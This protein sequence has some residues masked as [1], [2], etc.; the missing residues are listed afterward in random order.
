MKLTIFHLYPEAM[1]L[2]G[3][4][5]NILTLVKRCQWRGIDVE[6]SNIKVG[7]KADF[8]QADLI[9]LGGG[10]DRGQSIIAPDLLRKGSQIKEAV[11]NGAV[12][13]TICGGYQLFGKYF[14]TA[15]GT[16]IK[17]IE[18][19]DAYTVAGNRRLIG[20]VI[21]E[22]GNWASGQNQE[23]LVGFEN[24]S[25]KTILLND[26]SPLGTVVKGFGN[27]GEGKTEGAVYKNAF[28]TYLHGSLLPKN[29]WF[30]DYLILKGLKRKHLEIEGLDELDDTLEMDANVAA[31]KRAMTAKTTYI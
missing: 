25:G 27:D 13:L 29:P 3:D 8:N 1:N 15:E 23:K 7:D 12:S 31:Q 11:D 20:N 17:G 22:A 21:V 5:G 6:V 9:F 19:F 4:L 14:R 16:E 24:H 28:G 2:Y 30:A 26:L 10:Q 18:V